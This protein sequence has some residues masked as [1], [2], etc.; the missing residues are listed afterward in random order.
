M[1]D[2]SRHFNREEFACQC[3]AC[4]HIAVDFELVVVLESVREHFNAPITIT[5]A[6][7]CPDHNADVGGAEKSQHLTGKAADIV[8]KGV[9]PDQVY[10]LIDGMFPDQYG[11]GSYT[12]FTHIDTR[13]KWNRW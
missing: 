2:L 9:S 3:G 5:S 1:G 10:K 8:V 7:R 4:D 11:I 13:S 6:Y 12:T